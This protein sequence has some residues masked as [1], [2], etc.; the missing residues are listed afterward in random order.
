[1]A[2]QCLFPLALGGLLAPASEDGVD[3]PGQAGEIGGADESCQ[4]LPLRAGDP[5]AGNAT[6]C[7]AHIV[8]TVSWAGVLTMCWQEELIWE[9]FGF[10]GEAICERRGGRLIYTKRLSSLSPAPDLTDRDCIIS[11]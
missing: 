11:C 10:E 9:S 4:R 7:V 6:W 8:A 2:P 5:A 3:S 1:M